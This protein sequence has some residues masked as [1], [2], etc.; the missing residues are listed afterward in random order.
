MTK[1]SLVRFLLMAVSSPC[2]E[3]ILM[4]RDPIDKGLILRA[5]VNGINPANGEHRLGILGIAKIPFEDFEHLMPEIEKF[6][7]ATSH[8]VQRIDV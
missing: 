7:E 3:K 1:D 6:I 4:E 5:C 2:F 8:N